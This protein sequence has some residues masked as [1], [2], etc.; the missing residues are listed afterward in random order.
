MYSGSDTGLTPQVIKQKI[1]VSHHGYIVNEVYGLDEGKDCLICM[2][3]PK[4]TILLPCR[5][6]CLCSECSMA[7]RL[8]TN[9]CP[10]C[11]AKVESLLRI[12][13]EDN[14]S[15]SMCNTPLPKIDENRLSEIYER[16]SRLSSVQQQPQSQPQSQ[17]QEQL[18][19]PPQIQNTSFKPLESI[20]NINHANSAEN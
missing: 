5:H 2:S 3:A 20:N 13:K 7:L 4:N 8:Q 1:H 19:P 11:R 16:R 6:I 14:G 17:Q 10:V 15:K 12:E 9:K 18:P